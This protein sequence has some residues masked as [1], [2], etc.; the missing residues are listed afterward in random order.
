M[1]CVTRPR[2][3]QVE[4]VRGRNK[5][6]DIALQW[7]FKVKEIWPTYPQKSGYFPEY[8]FAKIDPKD[9]GIHQ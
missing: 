1:I 3:T 5:K 8:I 7:T 4:S 2:I 6:F 9:T